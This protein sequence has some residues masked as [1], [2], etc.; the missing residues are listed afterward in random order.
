[1]GARR[2]EVA[3]SSGI[4]IGS[5]DIA[6]IAV[7]LPDIMRRWHISAGNVA[8]LGSSTLIG[9]VIGSL[10][11][12][13]LADRYGRRLVLLLDFFT[14]GIAALLSA[15]SP[16]LTWL[17]TSRVVVGLGVGAD[18][19]V[20]FPYLVEFAGPA[21]RGR[22]MAWAM[23]AANFGMLLAYGVGA[24]ALRLPGGWRIPLGFGA[25]LVI[26]VL[27][28]RRAIPESG[29]WRLHRAASWSDVKRILATA[30]YR[31]TVGWSSLTWLSY[32]VSDQGL[33]LFLPLMFVT[34]FGTSVA[35]AA[36]HSVLVKAVTIPAALLTVMLIDRWGRR[37]LQIW[38][39][40]GRTAG[41]IG[42]G[43]L[44]FAVPSLRNHPDMVS[45]AWILL[46]VAYAFGAFGP[47]KTTVIT[48]AERVSTE[49][50]ASS[51]AVAEA[52]GRVGGIIGIAGYAFLS[53]LWGP[54]AG[55][56][57]FGVMALAGLII[58]QLTLPETKNIETGE[59][60]RGEP[61]EGRKAPEPSS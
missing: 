13:P 30:Q 28:S 49:V 17:I 19:A 34:V 25:L 45:A 57:F 3:V 59:F 31:K 20:V 16:D 46:V 40:A 18:F 22:V 4:F 24:L 6:A 36:W 5:Y 41:L 42:L 32:Q 14:Y 47:D 21:N 50:R 11:A 26:P 9:M 15:L 12:G 27:W 29:E 2:T 52:S 10:A 54:G 1:M 7:A 56:M 51:Q 8:F 23:W 48:T 55:V 53:A 61:R 35:G 43:V 60:G 58:S 39:F 37:P 33:T 44:L 38:G